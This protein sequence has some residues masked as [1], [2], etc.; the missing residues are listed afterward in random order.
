[1]NVFELRDKLI[2]DYSSYIRSFI[3]TRDDRV[4]ALVTSCLDQGLLWSDPLIPAFQYAGTI[5]DLV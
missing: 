2:E 3:R 5:E 1:M 4:D